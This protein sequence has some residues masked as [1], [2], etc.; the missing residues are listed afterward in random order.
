MRESWIIRIEKMAYPVLSALAQGH[1]RKTLPNKSGEEKMACMHLE[2]MARTLVGL[3]PYLALNDNDP[4]RKKLA[5]LAQQS[6]V[7]AM[8]PESP[9]YLGFGPDKTLLH[10][11]LVDAAFF[12]HALLRGPRLFLEQPQE[13]RERILSFLRDNRRFIP[14]WNNWLLFSGMVEAALW[15]F[16]GECDLVRVDFILRQIDDWAVGDGFYSDGEHFALDYYNSFV[17]HPMFLDMVELFRDVLPIAGELLERVH[18]RMLRQCEIMERIVAPDGSF[19][20]V[21]RSIVYRCGAFQIP[22]QMAWRNELPDT[23]CLGAVREMLNAVIVRT[24]DA[25]ETY[26]ELGFLN[27]G[28]C[29]NQP[30]LGECYIST[31]SLY[32]ATTAF[33]PLGLPEDAA[34]WTAPAEPWSA[35]RIWS[36]QDVM[37]DHATG[38]K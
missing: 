18:A 30:H 12:A 5:V 2:A 13:I 35:R 28:L 16:S 33:L 32:L 25:P 6:I 4:V 11:T 31:G 20:A 21:G 36:G 15:K 10:Q 26:D 8:S 1:L 34:F 22:A 17:I 38:K 24:L 19:P 27:I 37:R 14:S 9:D 3:A 23:L 7:S 29:G